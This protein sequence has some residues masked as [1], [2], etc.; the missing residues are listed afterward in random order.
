[1]RS[2]GWIQLP[3]GRALYEYYVSPSE[4]GFHEEALKMIAP[5]GIRKKCND[6]LNHHIVFIGEVYVYMNVVYQKSSGEVVGYVR[7]D[8]V[9][10]EWAEIEKEICGKKSDRPPRYSKVLLSYLVKGVTNSI[11]AVVACHSGGLNL[12]ELNKKTWDVV[13]KLETCDIKVIA[14]VGSGALVNQ[15]FNRY[16]PITAT[17]SRVVFDTTNIHSKDGR[18]LFLLNDFSELLKL[19]RNCFANSGAH[20]Q[21]RLL[22]KNGE[23]I[24]WQTIIDI[25]QSGEDPRFLR[26]GKI[27]TRHVFLNNDSIMK[28]NIAAETMSRAVADAIEQRR[29]PGT[30]ET[31]KFIRYINDVSDCLSGTHVGQAS[32]QKNLNLAVYKSEG[33][34]R[35][36]FLTEFL[37]YLKKWEDEVRELPLLESERKRR[38]LSPQVLTEIER[39]IRAFIGAVKYLL[40]RRRNLEGV[41]ASV[42]QENPLGYSSKRR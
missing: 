7:L 19:I 1:M 22:T 16:E 12:E 38:L 30:A 39:T 14:L 24:S 36:F 17:D 10:A 34:Y 21:T 27:T 32:K 3:N 31:I 4:L 25:F 6:L 2:K 35:F 5:H 23:I 29:I 8:E 15:L 18:P 11:R 40:G 26:L 33:D 28:W 41:M 20:N 42:F 9:K 37:S 13:K